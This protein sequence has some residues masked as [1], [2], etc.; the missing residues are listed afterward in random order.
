MSHSGKEYTEFGKIIVDLLREIEMEKN[1][2]SV[3]HRNTL[4]DIRISISELAGA[5][6]IDISNLI[7]YCRGRK[8]PT[9]RITM[10][11]IIALAPETSASYRI[12]S[13]TGY[14]L[15]CKSAYRGYNEEW[16]QYREIVNMLDNYHHIIVGL[17]NADF[18]RRSNQ[19]AEAQNLKDR[20]FG[21]S[22]KILGNGVDILFGRWLL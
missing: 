11:I 12:F 22:E 19:I 5:A 6:E 15:T 1:K 17:D 20:I 21:E 10:R 8:H 13:E 2:Y 7:A 18:F 4:R 14:D 16:K 9:P 3:D